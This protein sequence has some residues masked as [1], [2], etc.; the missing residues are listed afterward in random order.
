M[1]AGLHTNVGENRL[2][3]WPESPKLRSAW[4]SPG[5]CLVSAHSHASANLSTRCL[6][7]PW[8]HIKASG[9]DFYILCSKRSRAS[10]VKS[11]YVKFCIV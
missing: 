11:I 9:W 4:M 8:M 10:S 1:H 7:P 6:S 3:L 2:G 5:T